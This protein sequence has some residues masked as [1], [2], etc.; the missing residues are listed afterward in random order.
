M[1]RRLINKIQGNNVDIPGQKLDS[2]GRRK[3]KMTFDELDFAVTKLR[4]EPADVLLC[5]TPWPLTA[6]QLRDIHARLVEHFGEDR[7]ILILSQDFDLAVMPNEA[8]GDS[9]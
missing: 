6:Q 2:V 3:E 5:R 9:A 8:H 4:L 7:K 1:M